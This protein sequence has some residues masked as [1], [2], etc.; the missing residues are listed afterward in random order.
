MRCLFLASAIATL[1]LSALACDLALA[2]AVDVSGSV[3]PTE[4]HTQMQ[5]LA[6]ALRDGVVS[7]ALVKAEAAVMLVQWTG[8]SRQHLT[9]PWRRI[10]TFSDVEAISAE[11]ESAPR[12]WRNFSTAI[13]EALQFTLAEWSN[14]PVCKRNIIDV[15]GDGVSNEGVQ[16]SSLHP[17]LTRAGITVNALAIEESEED[18]TGY[19]WTN[20]IWGGEGAFVVTANSFEDYPDRIRQKLI[21]ETTA[22]ISCALPTCRGLPDQG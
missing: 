7:E 5:G 13:G 17:V 14:A 12:H 11:I 2:L 18:L 21:R 22:Q 16:P 3:D 19:F 8:T 20:V 15:S 6:D 9:I 1:P 4:Y 10:H